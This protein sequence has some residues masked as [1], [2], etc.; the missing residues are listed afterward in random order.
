MEPGHVLI[1]TPLLLEARAIAEELDL[2]F[3]TTGT[4]TTDPGGTAARVSLHLIGLRAIRMSEF[5]QQQSR[6][7]NS[8]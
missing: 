6:P 3:D 8:K 2:R 1:F 5:I 4:T 7:Q